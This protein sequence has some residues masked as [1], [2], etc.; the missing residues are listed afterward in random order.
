MRL[1]GDSND[2]HTQRLKTRFKRQ[3]IGL[4]FVEY[5]SEFVV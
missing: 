5:H 1:V 4:S 3:K 2:D